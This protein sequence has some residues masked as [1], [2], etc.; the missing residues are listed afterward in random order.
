MVLEGK[1]AGRMNKVPHFDCAITRSSQDMVSARMELHGTHPIAMALARHDQLG[2]IDCPY[3][4]E[5]IVTARADD[6]FFG[7]E[8]HST[9]GHG[10]SLLRLP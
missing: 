8:D 1:S 4:P 7:M 5:H 2:L 10:M 6:G 9:D 3:F